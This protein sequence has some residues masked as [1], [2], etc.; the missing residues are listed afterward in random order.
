MVKGKNEA[1]ECNFSHLI[2][3]IQQPFWWDWDLIVI[4]ATV[5]YN[6]PLVEE[7]KSHGNRKQDKDGL[8][9]NVLSLSQT[10]IGQSNE[11]L[12]NIVQASHLIAHC[13]L[14]L[15]NRGV[16]WW[17]KSIWQKAHFVRG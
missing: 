7:R 2:G 12:V 11:W 10:A 13:N 8:H 3:I 9:R 15:G 6:M 14:Y 4:L 1:C 5:W 17:R 16:R